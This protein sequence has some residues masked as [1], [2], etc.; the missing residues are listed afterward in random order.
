MG[1]PHDA[2]T[3]LVRRAKA[4]DLTAF[5]EL[6]NR[7]EQRIYSLARRITGNDPD[8]EDVTQ[9][10]FLSALE[11]LATF[12]EEARF[13]TWLT[14]IAT[15]AALHVLRKRKGLRT[16]SLDAAAEAQPVDDDHVP[17]PEY[18]ADW[19]ES[20]EELVTRRETLQLIEDALAKLDEK[21]R[22]VFLLRDVEG[23]SIEETAA[24]TGLTET[25]VKVRLLRARLAL[26]EHL[27]QVLGD[28]ATRREPHR[29][30]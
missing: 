3:E 6:V 23:L 30:V 4:G 10:T 7:H 5:E 24:I 25:N 12:R 21:Y 1:I 2:E 18:I 9:Q 27:T 14:R 15:H 13:G 29:H 8:A 11:H 17:H 26:R 19:R 16:E 20:P 28:P 22:V